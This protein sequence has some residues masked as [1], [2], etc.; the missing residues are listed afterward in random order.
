LAK[1]LFGFDRSL[2]TGET[3][4][5]TGRLSFG[6]TADLRKAECVVLRCQTGDGAYYDLALR[7]ADGDFEWLRG[8]LRLAGVQE[9]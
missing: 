8:A 3:T 7:P 1:L 9:S 4:M 5:T 6:L 2:R